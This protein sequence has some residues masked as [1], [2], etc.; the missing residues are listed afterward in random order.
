MAGYA[1]PG[2]HRV[3]AVGKLI[4]QGAADWKPILEQGNMPAQALHQLLIGEPDKIIKV[5]GNELIVIRQL[6]FQVR[7][8]GRIGIAV[9]DFGK[10]SG[11]TQL[12][13]GSLKILLRDF[14]SD[15]QPSGRD[16]LFRRVSLRAGYV[17]REKLVGGQRTCARMAGGVC[18]LSL[19]DP[20]R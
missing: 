5:D 12:L 20:K 3:E 8:L 19:R 14:L 4:G 2:Q 16:N 1:A 10:S 15:A 17:D 11:L 9:G 13:T 6:D 7:S 18:K